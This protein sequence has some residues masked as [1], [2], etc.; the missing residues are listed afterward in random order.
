[1]CSEKP[2]E[3]TGKEERE[4]LTGEHPLGDAGQILIFLLFI[5][6][7]VADS[8]F[9]KYSASLAEEVSERVH[10]Q[11]GIAEHGRECEVERDI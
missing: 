10:V 4:D 11:R 6:L 1:M 2:P 3:G 9:W 7:W 5:G 8:I